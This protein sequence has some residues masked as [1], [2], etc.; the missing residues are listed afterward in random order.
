MNR[1]RS[2]S[3]NWFG[4]Y[5]DQLSERDI[6]TSDTVFWRLLTRLACNKIQASF[7]QKLSS[8]D[9]FEKEIRTNNFGDTL[10]DTKI[11]TNKLLKQEKWESVFAK[12]SKSQ[13]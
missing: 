13:V 7:I 4:N 10:K 12:S 11:R 3:S 2:L 6:K 8:R 9:H 5:V 1:V